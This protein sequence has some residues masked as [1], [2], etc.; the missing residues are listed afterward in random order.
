MYSFVSSEVDEEFKLHLNDIP[1]F[2][3]SLD[4]EGLKPSFLSR[5][6]EFVAPRVGTGTVALLVLLTKAD[7][8]TRSEAALA[9]AAAQEV[10]AG[11]SSEA[12]DVGV[13]LFSALRKTG[14]ADV[15]TALL[16]WKRT[17]SKPDAAAV[18]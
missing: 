17:G 8:L 11:Y 9:L 18:T 10:L 15:A 3:E 4:V 1:R 2:R 12:S 16:G 6:L 7:K 5:L 13:A 14:V